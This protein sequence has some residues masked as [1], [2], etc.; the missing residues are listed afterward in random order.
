MVQNL[1]AHAVT[2]GDSLRAFPEDQLAV[3]ARS[4]RRNASIYLRD[5]VRSLAAIPEERQ[6]ARSD[7]Q[8]SIYCDWY[9]CW[10]PSRSA[11]CLPSRSVRS[12]TVDSRPE[13][14]SPVQTSRELFTA[15]LPY[16]SRRSAYLNLHARV[17]RLVARSG[18]APAIVAVRVGVRRGSYLPAASQH[19]CVG[20][21][22]CLYVQAGCQRLR[23]ATDPPLP[24]CTLDPWSRLHWFQQGHILELE[25][26]AD[27]N[28]SSKGV[29]WLS[30]MD[31][32]A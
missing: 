15:E 32:L 21:N 7:P 28:V 16:W 26:M 19:F 25:L 17:T 10:A 29:K 9:L 3:L 4:Y 13:R 22:G 30:Q 6:I 24:A 20:R 2:K 5:V 1:F 18:V 27:I 31:Y 23:I 11:H 14:A 8:A 12:A